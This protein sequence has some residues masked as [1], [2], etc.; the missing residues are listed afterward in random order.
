MHGYGRIVH[1]D[2]EIEEGLY[3]NDKFKAKKEDVE[4]YNPNV[5]LLAK[6]I[7]FGKYSKGTNLLH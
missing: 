7:V 2:G 6:K 5:H 1:S 3:D 4:N